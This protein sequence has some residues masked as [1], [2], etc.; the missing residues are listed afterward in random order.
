M[1][2]DLGV[3]ARSMARGAGI[4]VIGSLAATALGFLVMVAITYLV[5]A[6]A[7]GLVAIGSTLVGFAMIPALLGLDTGVI[8]FVARRAS[9]G[10]EHG[11][12]GSVQAAMTVA[13]TTSIALTV[14]LWWQAPEISDWFFRK[15]EATEIVRLVSLSLPALA[16]GRVATAAIQGYGLMKYP[17]WLG[18]VRRGL[19]L[20][21]LLPLVAVGL[22]AR[23]LALAGVVSA[24]ASCALAFYFLLRVHPRVLAPVRNWPLLSL[25]NFSL[26]QVMT[27]LLFFAILW[28][29]T[30]FLGRF[31]TAAEVGVYTVLAT[32]LGPATL[33]STAVGEMFAPRIAA[34]D[35]RGDRAALARMLKRVTHWN[36]TVALPFFA[37]LALV[38]TGLLSVFGGRYETGAAALA[39]LALGQLL[40]TVAGPLGQVINMSGRQYLT[41]TNNAFVA[42][43]NAA[44]CIYLIPRYGMTGAACSTAG[45]LTLVNLIKLV[46]VRLL[47]SMHPFRR[48]TL[49]VV[50]VGLG[51]LAVAAP[52]ALV[53]AWPS[54]AVEAAVGGVVLF[55]VYGILAW[56]LALTDE[57]RELVEVG[58]ARI[59]RGLRLPRFATGG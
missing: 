44:G 26:P 39:I 3:D 34:E 57:D 45:S 32:L 24:W 40:N 19:R 28:T 30:L 2:T 27:G 17:A 41:M 6:R 51:A 56:A 50:F 54:A 1:R 59:R 13:L 18:I 42:A 46:E 21:A 11:T 35:G 12:R 31:G 36:T 8:R 38:P 49:R 7:I 25:L 23:G 37:V 9:V 4:N 15:P 20:A 58:R 16:L 53:P 10:D 47:F 33:V 48:Q 52:V 22:E 14:V 5:S 29:D 55:A 43:I